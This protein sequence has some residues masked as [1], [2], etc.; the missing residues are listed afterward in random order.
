LAVILG[1]DPL[2]LT[3]P[4][5][6]AASCAFMLPVATPP[7]AIVFGSGYI[8]MGHMVRGGAILNLLVIFL[9][10][11]LSYFA[12]TFVFGGSIANGSP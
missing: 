3:V 12:V 4:A 11:L 5:A 9:V 2:Y 1:Q 8:R 7:N 6:L 10:P